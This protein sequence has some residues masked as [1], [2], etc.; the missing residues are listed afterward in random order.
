MLRGARLCG[1]GLRLAAAAGADLRGADL[2]GMDLRRVPLRGA[3]LRG[4]CWAAAAA[5]RGFK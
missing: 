3:D 2:S 1:P 5:R 4:A